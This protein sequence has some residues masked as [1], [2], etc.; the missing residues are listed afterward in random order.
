MNAAGPGHF[1]STASVVRD[2]VEMME[3]VGQEKLKYWG[4]SYGTYIGTTFAA[5][6]PNKVGRIVNDGKF[7]P[8]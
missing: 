4:F 3:K 2:I 5:M 6:Y 8:T 7:S 1:V